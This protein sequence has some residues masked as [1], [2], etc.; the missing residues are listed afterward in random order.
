MN[1]CVRDVETIKEVMNIFEKNNDRAA[2]VIN[3]TNKVIGV[4]SEG[5]IIRALSENISI[6]APVR[7]ILRPSFLYLEDR[8]MKKAYTIFKSKMISLLPV[9][10]KDF[11][12]QGVITI[13]DIFKYLEEK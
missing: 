3:N 11:E 9:V 7:T 13:N 1:H 12:L 10:N 5:D 4:I 2:I 8:D 6:Y